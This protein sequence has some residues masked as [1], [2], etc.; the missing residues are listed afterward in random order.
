M[1]HLSVLAAGLIAPTLAFADFRGMDD[2]QIVDVV[3][4]A[5]RIAIDTGLLAESKSSNHAVKAFAQRKMTDHNAMHR[6]A[7]ELVEKLGLAPRDSMIG[8]ELRTD[9]EKGFAELAAMQGIEFDKA[10]IDQNVI[11]HQH[12]LDTIDNRLMPSASSEELK[13]LLYNMFAPLSDH[14]EHALQVQESLNN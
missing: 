2:G 3:M 7:A 12:V 6:L 14:L 11:L 10:Y 8:N 5:N 9:N 4:T 1:K 13:A